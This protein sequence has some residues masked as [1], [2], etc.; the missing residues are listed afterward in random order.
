MPLRMVTG[1][2]SVVEVVVAAV[3]LAAQRLRRDPTRG[4]GVLADAAA[5][6]SAAGVARGDPPRARQRGG[7]HSPRGSDA[8]SDAVSVGGQ[9]LLDDVVEATGEFVAGG[10]VGLDDEVGAVAVVEVEPR[11]RS[12]GARIGDPTCARRPPTIPCRTRCRCRT[13]RR[14]DRSASDRGRR[15]TAPGCRRT[16]RRGD[17]SAAARR[18]RVP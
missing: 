4:I 6:R 13:S 15:A 18:S 3:L 5:P 11:D 17:A 2:A 7:G 1:A 14:F 12:V 16:C 9:L 10:G 8:W